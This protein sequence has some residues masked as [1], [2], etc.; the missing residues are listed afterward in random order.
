MHRRDGQGH[1]LLNK[2]SSVTGVLCWALLC[3]A[4]AVGPTLGAHPS[5]YQNVLVSFSMV[6]FPLLLIRAVLITLTSPG[7]RRA[8]LTLVSGLA[9][10][11]T[12]SM[13]LNTNQIPDVT[14]FPAPGEWLFL[15][16]YL[17]LAAYLILDRTSR[18]TSAATT[19]LDAVVVCGG[20][21]C[22]TASVLITPISSRFGASGLPLL[23]ALLYP[24]ID[25]MLGV[26]VVGQ[27]A[28]RLRNDLLGSLQLVSG[29]VLFA[30]ADGQFVL[31]L[32]TGTYSYSWI[33][34]VAW[35]FGFAQLITAA[36]RPTRTARALPRR[37]GPTVL[38]LSSAAAVLVLAFR[39]SGGFGPLLAVTA[40]VTLIAG[41]LRLAVAL[42][43]ANGAAEAFAL[44]RTDDLTLLPNRRE[45]RAKLDEAVARR[46]QFGLLILDLDGFKEVNDTLGHSA[47]DT[48]LQISA[49]RIRQLL[50]PEMLTA[51]L[52]G[53]E[54][55]VL[56]EG[57][58]ISLM[59]AAQQVIEVISAPLVVDGIELLIKASVGITV[60]GEGDTSVDLL[61]RADVAM[62]Q[63]KR[64][65]VGALVYDAHADD[66][67]RE[68][69][70]LARD[71][72]QGLTEGQMVLWY[73]PQI[74]ASTGQLCGV[75]A[76]IRW[77]HP[78]YG[79][80]APAVFLPAA[81]RAGLMA[82]ISEEVGRLAVNDLLNWRSDGLQMRVAINC[83]PPELLSGVFL[84]RLFER[85]DRAQLPG[86]SLVIEM[87]ED[88]FL[89]DP[90]RARTI[91]AD[92]RRHD[93]QVAIDDYGTGFS[94][95]SY[96]RDLPVQELKMDRSFISAIRTDERSRMIV[97]ST[98]SMAQ[99]LG[100]RMVAE[101]VE[102]AATAADL[103]AMGVD[104]L[105]GYHVARPMPAADI[106]GWIRRWRSMAHQVGSLRDAG[107]SSGSTAA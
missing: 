53:D 14:K 49:H 61:R 103:V 56:A 80:L 16:A 24:I 73:Q 50:P 65:E 17:C 40:M 68:K 32:H 8:L 91:I 74:E 107:P 39:P 36:A 60:R 45:L 43:E 34:D 66:F 85:I 31:N 84:P 11:S 59:E 15:A 76:L 13:T 37:Q 89:S 94:S 75:E 42:R 104:V 6:F 26:L 23:V 72:R 48:V 101:G 38:V 106:E 29:F 64:A 18:M 52:G 58:E 20:T 92:I 55:A 77:N 105:Q 54:F 19:W 79:M 4:A 81:R 70:E 98:F 25:L 86:D 3:I 102:D 69:L 30:F 51:R 82:Q 12:G 7:R 10:W 100:V 63:A 87:T 22:V 71:L 46:K 9:L 21:T 33:Q 5:A 27:I 97:A 41:G 57:D 90:E 67:S 28:L 95:L 83:A 2:L 1:G 96:L 99:A 44:S 78:Q 93:V 88:V 35:G 62:Y 47:G